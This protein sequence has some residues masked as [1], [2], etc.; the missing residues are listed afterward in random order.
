MGKMTPIT[1]ALP[2]QAQAYIDEQLSVVFMP[3]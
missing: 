1:I 2:E 3:L